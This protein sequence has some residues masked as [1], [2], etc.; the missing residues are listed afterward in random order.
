[1][2][3]E[4]SNIKCFIIHLQRANKRKKFV[5]EIINNVPIISEIINAVDGNSLSEKKINSIL[6]NKKIY[7]EI[8]SRVKE[9]K[10]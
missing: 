3:S 6:S 4:L 9:L 7:N 10:L 8:I 1:M 2:N 5:K